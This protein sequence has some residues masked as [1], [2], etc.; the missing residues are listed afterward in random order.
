MKYFLNFIQQI[1]LIVG[2]YLLSRKQKNIT[3]DIESKFEKNPSRLE[4]V[5]LFI[6]LYQLM[7]SSL[8]GCVFT[9][10]YANGFTIYYK[11]I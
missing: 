8:Y 3:D 1:P 4:F 9:Y 6:V 2:S 5:D 7:F 10:L 11:D